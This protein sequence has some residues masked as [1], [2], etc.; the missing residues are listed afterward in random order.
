MVR[1]GTLG[2]LKLAK[3]VL[4]TT[5]SNYFILMHRILCLLSLRDDHG[6]NDSI[7]RT[8]FTLSQGVQTY[9]FYHHSDLI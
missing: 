7:P 5:S 1:S 4:E 6:G 9:T 8:D 3:H 2:K